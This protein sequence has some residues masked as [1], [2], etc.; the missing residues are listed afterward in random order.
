[1]NLIELTDSRFWFSDTFG[2]VLTLKAQTQRHGASVKGQALGLLYGAGHESKLLRGRIRSRLNVLKE[3]DP[4]RSIWIWLSFG[5]LCAGIHPDF[6]MLRDMMACIASSGPNTWMMCDLATKSRF[7]VPRSEQVFWGP[8][9]CY[10]LLKKHR[11]F[12]IGS[13]TYF[14]VETCSETWS[15]LRGLVTA[16]LVSSSLHPSPWSQSFS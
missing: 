5:I 3:V 4:W 16:L 12:S 14:S 6:C 8:Q 11:K 10:L 9:G 2:Q 1:M 15:S 7:L 13:L